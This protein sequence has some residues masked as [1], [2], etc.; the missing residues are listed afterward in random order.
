MEKIRLS[1]VILLFFTGVFTAISVA[2]TYLATQDLLSSAAIVIAVTAG[3]FAGRLLVEP[4]K[5]ISSTADGLSRAVR[6][7]NILL[8]DHLRA[9]EVQP[10]DPESLGQTLRGVQERLS[11]LEKVIYQVRADMRPTV[12]TVQATAKQPDAG[13]PKV[14]VQRKG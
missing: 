11:L 1:A 14:V 7:L 5:E 13:Q 6:E 8:S 9:H 10:F 2:I 12:P 3:F 4:E